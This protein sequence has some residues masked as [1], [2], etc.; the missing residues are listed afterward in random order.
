MTKNKK[1][2]QNTKQ[3]KTTQKT[4]AQ[5]V[6][7][8]TAPKKV[9]NSLATRRNKTDAQKE[10]MLKALEATLG[11]VTPAAKVAGVRRQ[12]HYDWMQRDAAYKQQVDELTEMALD[13]AE[14][15]LHKLIQEGNF[16]ATIFFL[17]TKGRNR[18]YVERQEVQATNFNFNQEQE[19]M[20]PEKIKAMTDELNKNL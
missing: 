20:T 19:Q 17:K 13:F 6:R 7:K 2:P 5:T 8:K 11:V 10:A 3:P 1:E 16:T 9:V 14:S 18:G 12:T 15:K 4:A